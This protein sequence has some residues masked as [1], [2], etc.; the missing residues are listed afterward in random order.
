MKNALSGENSWCARKPPR[1][2]CET[3]AEF[4]ASYLLFSY[5]HISTSATIQCQLR[6]SHSPIWATYGDSHSRHPVLAASRDPTS[7]RYRDSHWDALKSTVWHVPRWEMQL[8]YLNYND[9]FLG[10]EIFLLTSD[11]ALPCAHEVKYVKQRQTY[12]V[13]IL[14][15]GTATW[16]RKQA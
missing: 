9:C 11:I 10:N 3:S 15:E 8:F 13:A 5:P 14:S 4:I 1:S 7:A 2:V 12:I 16:L 6:I